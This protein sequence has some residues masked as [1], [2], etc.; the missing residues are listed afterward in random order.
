MSE[1]QPSIAYELPL[2][3]RMR[4]FMRMEFLFRQAAHHANDKTEWGYRQRLSALLDVIQLLSRSDVR[5]EVSKALVESIHTLERLQDNPEVDSGTLSSILDALRSLDAALQPIQAQ[6]ASNLLR[7]S[8]FLTSIVNRS[9]VPG[10]TAAFD[11]PGYQ[12]WLAQGEA[13]CDAGIA[14]WS[15][16]LKLF[17]EG[18]DFTLKLIRDSAHS[19]QVTAEGGNYMAALNS[20]TQLLRILL[21]AD[22]PFYPATSASRHRCNIRFLQQQGE[23]PVTTPAEQD[24]PFHLACC[25]L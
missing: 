16:H 14:H 11:M 12:R 3:E 9:M 10:G 1:T 6:F 18:I 17:E 2:S 24:V 8:D 7:D 25:G 4:T 23:D 22:S 19:K 13:I 20:N 15:R 5:T 21:P